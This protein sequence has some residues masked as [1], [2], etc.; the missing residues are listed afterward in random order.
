MRLSEFTRL[1]LR[2]GAAIAV[3]LATG[4]LLSHAGSVRL[5][6]IQALAWGVADADKS[7][8]FKSPGLELRDLA[9]RF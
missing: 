5:D 1:H 4:L 2:L 8:I 9:R 7:L 6:A 3:L